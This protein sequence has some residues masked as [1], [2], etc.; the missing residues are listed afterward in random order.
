MH[1]P[2][3]TQLKLTELICHDNERPSGIYGFGT[4]HGGLRALLHFTP[5]QIRLENFVLFRLCNQFR[6]RLT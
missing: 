5:I 3:P 4:E 2:R 1:N 6:H